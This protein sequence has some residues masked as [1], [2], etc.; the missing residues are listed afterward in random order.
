MTFALARLAVAT[1]IAATSVAHAG[2]PVQLSKEETQKALAG[3][4]IT[5]EARGGGVAG[6]SVVI[7][8]ATE[9]RMTFKL[10]GS[11]K[12]SS[13]TWSVD[14]DGRYCIK[15][16]SGTASDGCRH[17]LKTDTGYAMKTGRGE[18][19]PVDKLE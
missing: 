15:I 19:V 9:G 13:G 17:L 3:K 14:D 5:Y 10:T 7:F 11:P 8:F 12:I 16:I 2:D 1:A 6:G 4:S 18:I